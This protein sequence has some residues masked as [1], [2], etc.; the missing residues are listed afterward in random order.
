[1]K[2]INWQKNGEKLSRN[3]FLTNH[4]FLYLIINSSEEV[5]KASFFV[6]EST[7]VI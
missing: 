2:I 3:V 7:I 5:S 1:M 4:V 6:C